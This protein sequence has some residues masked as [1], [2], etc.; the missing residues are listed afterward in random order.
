MSQRNRVVLVTG[1]GRGIGMG[2]ATALAS[3]G[4]SIALNDRPGA[5]WL[6]PARDVVRGMTSSHGGECLAIEEDAFSREG[7]GRIL[8]QTL[9]HFGRID[10]LVSNPAFSVRAAFLEY[11]PVDFER[12][13][14]G[15]LTAG[16]HMSQLVSRELVRQGEGGGIVFISSVQAEMPLA[17]SVAYGAAKAG[18]NHM[19]R[20]LSVEL[21]EH[22]IRANVIEPGWIDTPGERIVF[23]A[24]V[25]ER[26]GE[27]L[28][29]RRLGM[30]EDIGAAAAFLLSEAAGY[31]TGSVLPVDGG[32]RFK[33]CRQ[34]AAIPHLRASS[35][36]DQETDPGQD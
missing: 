2:C 32:F 9:N 8:E 36:L 13:L 10:A 15:T 34:D 21:A 24:E 23:S 6:E 19:M 12:V 27:R 17:G 29:L 20:T 4:W 35:E 30:P 18:L 25:I 26:E 16:F 7:C 11:D 14:N 31:I 3:Q 33:D 1:G 22:R 28:P 5:G